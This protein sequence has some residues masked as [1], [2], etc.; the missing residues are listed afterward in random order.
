MCMPPL[1]SQMAALWYWISPFMEAVDMNDD[2]R[3]L[4]WPLTWMK[5]AGVR[6]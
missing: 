6:W 5:G 2:R 1:L 4:D 3:P